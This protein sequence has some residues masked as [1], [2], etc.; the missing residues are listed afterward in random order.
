[1]SPYVH[2][3]MFQSPILLNIDGSSFLAALCVGDIDRGADRDLLPN[4][5]CLRTNVK[6]TIFF[7]FGCV[8]VAGL[9]GPHAKD[10]K[11][12]ATG[13]DNVFE[14]HAEDIPRHSCLV[15]QVGVT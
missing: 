6:L 12:E 1:M 7:N 2:R 5:P 13:K 11:R 15:A 4:F 10:V 9:H 8:V 14:T 3:N